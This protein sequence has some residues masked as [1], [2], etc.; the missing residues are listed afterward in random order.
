MVDRS[1][2]EAERHGDLA[3]GLAGRNSRQTLQLTRAELNR[4]RRRSPVLLCQNSAP[5][6]RAD[7]LGGHCLLPQTSRTRQPDPY[8]GSTKPPSIDGHDRSGNAAPSVI[9]LVCIAISGNGQV[10]A[11][12][13]QTRLRREVRSRVFVRYTSKL[14]SLSSTWAQVRRSLRQQEPGRTVPNQARA[15]WRCTNQIANGGNA[16]H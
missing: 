3:R 7:E 11:W 12:E 13:A 1:H 6:N 9:G 10:G 2:G 15:S 14:Y 4:G 5:P 16:S 8:A